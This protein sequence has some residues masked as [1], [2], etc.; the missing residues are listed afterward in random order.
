MASFINA[1]VLLL[2]QM[3]FFF[4]GMAQL[5]C[6]P[7]LKA[8][9]MVN[10]TPVDEVSRAIVSLCMCAQKV[11]FLSWP[12]RAIASTLLCIPTILNCVQI[13]SPFYQFRSPPFRS[14]F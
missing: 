2:N 7:I 8:E 4:S 10:V 9:T 5:G 1:D 3:F 13:L 12:C 14:F 6:A 11:Y